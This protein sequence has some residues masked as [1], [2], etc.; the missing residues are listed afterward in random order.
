MYVVPRNV[1]A[2]DPNLQ[3]STHSNLT[4]SS[5]GL[6]KKSAGAV[7]IQPVDTILRIP[8]QNL[9][10]ASP[11]TTGDD[12]NFLFICEEGTIGN[13]SSTPGSKE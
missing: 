12:I 8:G 7:T 2:D 4:P 5:E 10:E 6:I 13:T 11:G 9:E 3:G 1:I